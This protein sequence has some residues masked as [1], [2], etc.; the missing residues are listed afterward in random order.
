MPRVKGG[1]GTHK[2]HKKIKK[3]VKGFIHIRRASYRKAKEALLKSQ[4]QAFFGRK[5]KKRAFRRLWISRINAKA[6]ELG[7]SYSQLINLLNKNKIKLDRKILAKLAFEYPEA[8]RMIIEEVK[9]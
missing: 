7:L 6:K 2:R 3:Q 1:K 9:K 5:R 8:F 4:S